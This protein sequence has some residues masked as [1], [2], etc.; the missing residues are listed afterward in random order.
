MTELALDERYAKAALEAISFDLNEYPTLKAASLSDAFV[1][2]IR[3][4]AGS[5]KTSWVFMELLRRSIE[6]APGQDG[7]RRTKWLVGR[8]TYQVLVSA[9]LESAARMLGSTFRARESIPPTVKG[10]FDLEDGTKVDVEFEFLS[11]EGEDAMAKLLGG[12]WTGAFLDEVSEVPEKVIH[13]VLRRL[14]RYPSA[15]HGK[16]TWVGLI[17]V[18]NGPIEGHWLQ[19]W[20]MG[21]NAEL[22]GQLR[23]EIAE[24]TGQDRPFFH[25]F[26][27]PA[28]L[29]RPHDKDGQWRPNPKAENVKNLNGGYGYYFIML[30]DADDAKIR[31]FVEGEFA[32]LKQGKLVF[33]SF[34]KS[35]HVVP[36]AEFQVPAGVPVGLSFDFGR[37]PVCGVYVTTGSGRLV[38]VEE[39]MG[40]DIS[41]EGLFLEK[42]QPILRQRY[43]T[44]LIEWATGDP[45]GAD[46]RDNVDLSP[47]QVLWN[48]GVPVEVAGSNRL[49]PR[50][51]AVKQRLSRNDSSGA[52]MLSI[53]S[54]CAFTIEAMS[55]SYIYEL[56]RSGHDTVRDKPT[57]SHVNWVSDLADQLQY[58]CQ[59][60]ALEITKKSE[61]VL[62]ALPRRWA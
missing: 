34:R 12:E 26:A 18:T 42:I 17:C 31:A 39:V 45:T 46:K 15:S 21:E 4:P 35:M 8:L 47:F 33:P 40:E 11:L 60:N 41:I 3:G 52:P 55:R 27:Q 38:M 22:L 32:P 53:R 49:E 19:K 24:S 20:E 16:P 54:N 10:K 59:F 50:L 13:A 30:A 2:T 56:V 36:E 43:R 61:R 51:E 29:L 48:L 7:V 6:Q 1:R 57:K 5:A 25:A 14:G 9:T 58:A 37:T 62:P 44:S 23:R 28:A